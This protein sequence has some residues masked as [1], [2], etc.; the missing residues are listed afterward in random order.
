MFGCV[1]SRN[2]SFS[3]SKVCNSVVVEFWELLNIG[4]YSMF[5]KE[6]NELVKQ[7]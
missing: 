6:S 5:L 2:I 1:I 3:L 7:L 4:T